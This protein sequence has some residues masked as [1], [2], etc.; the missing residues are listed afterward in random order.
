MTRR[1][2]GRS[3]GFVG[4]AN[5]ERLLDCEL[6]VSMLEHAVLPAAENA[7]RADAVL[8]FHLSLFGDN[9]A[10][11]ELCHIYISSGHNFFGHHG[12]EPVDYAAVELSSIECLAARGCLRAPFFD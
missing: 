10:A 8:L 2:H 11:V 12:R 6:I 1:A 5:L 3:H 4:K 7:S 9:L